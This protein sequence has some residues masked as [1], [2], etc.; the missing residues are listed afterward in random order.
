M[1]YAL[2]DLEST[3]KRLMFQYRIKTQLHNNH[4]EWL[5]FLGAI[6][7]IEKG[8]DES[9][10]FEDNLFYQLRGQ[11][12]Q[13]TSIQTG[14]TEIQSGGIAGSSGGVFTSELGKQRLS[15]VWKQYTETK[16]KL[17]DY[18]NKT[19]N[20][21]I[22]ESLQAF[23]DS[24]MG[25]FVAVGELTEARERSEQLARDFGVLNNTI[26]SALLDTDIYN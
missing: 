7:G 5:E 21:P 4:P 2:H 20:N 22:I 26:T 13:L 1:V 18:V 15:E 9:A 10:D 25:V 8:S 11:I 24:M 6:G 17:S 14:K 16:D 3:R 12:E 23:D 19:E